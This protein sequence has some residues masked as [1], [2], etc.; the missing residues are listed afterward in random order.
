MMISIVGRPNVGKSSIFNRLSGKK[1]ALTSKKAGMTRDVREALI[2][3]NKMKLIICDM[4]GI[5]PK[6]ENDLIKRT[7]EKIIQ[8]MKASDLLLMVY[9]LSEGINFLDI[10]ISKFILKSGKEIILIGNKSD[11]KLSSE[12]I[13]DGWRLGLGEPVPVSAEH[14]KGFDILYKKLKTFYDKKYI[15]KLN[16]PLEKRI[17]NP[18]NDEQK[19]IKIAIIGKPNTGKST[20]VNKILGYERML[21]GTEAGIT[22]DSIENYFNWGGDRISLFDTAGLRRKSK[23]NKILEFN[24]VGDTLKSIKLS[25]VNLLMIDSRENITKQDFSIARW[26]IEEGRV[27]IVCLNMWDQISHKGQRYEFFINQ[28]KKSLSQVKEVSIIKVSGLF[29][30]GITQIMET[31][32]R[33]YKLWNKRIKTSS[34]NN[35]LEKIY[36]L[37]PPPMLNGKVIKLLYITQIKSRPPTFVIFINKRVELPKAYSRYL[38][39]NLT[40]EFGLSGIPIRMITKAKTNPYVEN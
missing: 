26:V 13:L 25:N 8:T 11:S 4:A 18:V 39:S 16:D 29:G 27:L 36:K 10:E 37:K 2:N 28:I 12:S 15:P 38:I 17:L 34:L 22:H 23:I 19:N 21:T 7:N 14:G 5:L 20:L 40:K 33:L 9:D 1:S 32:I 3:I 30:D 35:W 24:I 31:S 6:L